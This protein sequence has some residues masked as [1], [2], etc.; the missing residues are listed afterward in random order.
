MERIGFNT[1]TL[2]GV[3]H[4]EQ[5]QSYEARPEPFCLVQCDICDVSLE[6]ADLT[7][8]MQKDH[9]DCLQDKREKAQLDHSLGKRVLKPSLQR[10]TDCAKFTIKK[11]KLAHYKTDHMEFYRQLLTYNNKMQSENICNMC[12]H[13]SK[14]AKGI[15]KD[16]KAVHKKILD[17]KC[18]FCEMKF[19][20]LGNLKQHKIIHM[21]VH[22][23]Q[24]SIC[25]CKLGM[26]KL[27]PLEEKGG[28]EL[29]MVK[30]GV[31][32]EHYSITK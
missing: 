4:Q 32:L 29:L 1:E 17:F 25:G 28:L 13:V 5:T 2:L 23:F 19:F 26:P 8:H 9:E 20:N 7:K 22:P 6:V 10:C 16:K 11:E 30:Q 3:K 24:C 15:R 14:Y 27:K 18:K 21:K 12:G 31:E